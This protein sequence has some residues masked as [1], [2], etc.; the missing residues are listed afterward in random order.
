[1]S[2][3]SKAKLIELHE[4]HGSTKRVA[5]VLKRPRTTVSEWIEPFR[6]E[7][8][9]ACE[10]GRASGLSL[11]PSSD[12][13]GQYEE[14]PVIRRTYDASHHYVYPLGDIHLGAKAHH[15]KAWGEWIKY[16]VDHKGTS[17]IGTGDFLN[18]A[19]IGSKSDVYDER[20]TVGQAKRQFRDAIRPLAEEDRVDLLVR[21]NHEDRCVRVT[22]DDPVED[23]A[24][25][26]GV[27][28]VPASAL[29]VYEI[30]DIEYRVYVRHGTGNGQSVA[31]LEKSQKVMDADVYI[32]GHTHSQIVKAGEVFTLAEDGL[33]TKRRRLLYFSA[34]S[35]LGLEPYAAAKG[36][37]PTRIGAPRLYLDGRR[38]D[39]HGSI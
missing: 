21:G 11:T 27:P 34:G 6:E 16:L 31:A 28:Y 18:G 24:E 38:F 36:Y 3:P 12:P 14:I 19:I 30:G 20:L 23:V 17:M 29:I 25:F 9:E 5:D 26:L 10:R 22:G 4:K 2:K 7:C 8:R 35:F 13:E 1:M 33:T 39:M 37:A 15:A 32:T